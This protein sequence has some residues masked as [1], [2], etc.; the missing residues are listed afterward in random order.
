MPRPRPYRPDKTER[1]KAVYGR[2]DLAARCRIR[3]TDTPDEAIEAL[4]HQ[5][6]FHARP[7]ISFP[8]LH[9]RHAH[10]TTDSITL[11]I[12]LRPSISS[13][14]LGCFY[15]LTGSEQRHPAPL[16]FVNPRICNFY[17]LL[18]RL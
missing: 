8:S 11:P 14:D 13:E 18:M 2:L 1:V 17:I 12:S 10:A 5:H 16:T 4:S 7:V 9:Y 15:H 6:R 3:S